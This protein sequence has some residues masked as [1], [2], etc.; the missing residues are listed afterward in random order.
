M[1]AGVPIT[2]PVAGIS[3]GLM[4]DQKTGKFVLLT[5]IQGMEDHVGEMDFKITGTKDGITAIQLDVKND[6]L[7][8]EIC[9]QTFV[10]S[11]VAR[12][13]ILAKIAEALTAPRP[14]LSQYAPRIT[15]LRIDPAKIRDVIGKGGETINEIIDQC[16]GK[17][18]TK[19]D[20]EDDGLVMVTSHSS[21]MSNKAI[22]WIK[23]LTYDVQIGEEFEGK[24]TQI[25]ADRNS[26]AEIGAIVEFMPGKDGMVHISELSEERV[27]DVSSIVKVGD[28]MKVR[29][30]EVDKERG[31][32]SLS[33]KAV[34]K[35]AEE[36]AATR[37][38]ARPRRPF[39]HSG[40]YQG[41]GQ[42]GGG[43]NDRRG[44]GGRSF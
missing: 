16:G 4:T 2:K 15:S 14:E 42:R 39:G 23:Q 37:N 43:Y 29:V 31:R 17:D 20:I 32:I 30:M 18:V 7:T 8:M 12:D 34:G 3:I 13:T 24:V 1:D 6:G 22:E 27:P 41:G 25:V 35:S 28:T 38:A 9:E 33:H 19:I 36:I 21:E 11:K 44:G 5:D 40:G 26:G 10:R